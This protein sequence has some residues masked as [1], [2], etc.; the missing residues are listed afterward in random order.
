MSRPTTFADDVEIVGVDGDDT[1]WR[2]QEFFDAAETEL[3]ELLAP[4]GSPEQITAGIHATERGNLGLYGFGVKAWTLSMLELALTM[5]RHEAPPALLERVLAMGRDMLGGPVDVLPGA[6]DAV[7]ALARTHTVVLV[8][9]GDLVDQR[10]K[11][12]ASGLGPYFAHVEIV[13]D[14]TPEVYGELLRLLDCP[15]ERFLMVGNSEVSD[16]A[17]VL[18]LGG[19]AVHVPFRTTWALERAEP[20]QHDR[21]LTVASLADVPPLLVPSAKPAWSGYRRPGSGVR[22]LQPGVWWS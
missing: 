12:T 5:T 10:R 18:A 19:W 1:L 7:E 4:W 15:P 8:T 11:L 9:K 2:C 14:K 21:R 20:V 6:A 17:P 16:I 22:E 13:P 3:T